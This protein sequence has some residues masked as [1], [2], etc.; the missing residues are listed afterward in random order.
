MCY[1]TP[2]TVMAA[3]EAVLAG[4]GHKVDYPVRSVRDLPDCL[5]V[6]D[7]SGTATTGTRT[8]GRA[9]GADGT[10]ATGAGY[11]GHFRAVQGFRY[12]GAPPCE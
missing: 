6:T 1:R 3:A 8:A 12:L 9:G 2:A 7:L 11:G 10:T 4:L 5:E